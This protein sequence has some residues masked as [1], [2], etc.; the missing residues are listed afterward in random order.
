MKILVENL[1]ADITEERLKD[2]FSQIGEVQSVKIKTELLTRKPTGNGIVDMTLDIDG[3]RAIN[4]FE[5]ATF[6]DRQIHVK[7]AYPLLERAKR[8]IENG[9]HTHDLRIDLSRFTGRR[10]H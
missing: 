2:V 7:E 9:I 4:C 6:K 3:Y 1:P 5:G 10:D 8:M